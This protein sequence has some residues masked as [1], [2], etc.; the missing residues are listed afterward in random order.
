MSLLAIAFLVFA[1]PESLSG[2]EDQD[3][4]S[5]DQRSHRQRAIITAQGDPSLYES[6]M[7]PVTTTELTPGRV[8]D[9]PL[10]LPGFGSLFLVGDDPQSRAWLEHN[11][12]A[13]KK[14]SAVGLVVNIATMAGLQSLR[15]LAPGVLMVPVAGGDFAQRLQITHYPVLITDTGLSQQVSP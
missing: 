10:Q 7:L 1:E 4:A 9:R 15:Q 6:S 11:A 8:P 13:L 2:F 12:P 14:R 3:A 5:N